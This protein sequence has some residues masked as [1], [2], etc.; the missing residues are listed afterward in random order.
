MFPLGN[1]LVK[2]RHE[3]DLK[4]LIYCSLQM[5]LRS[6]MTICCYMQTTG[7]VTQLSFHLRRLIGTFTFAIVLGVVTE[8]ITKTVLVRARCSALHLRE[9]VQGT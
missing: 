9:A 1:R 7:F 8:D 5:T 2:N 4:V 3:K 6:T